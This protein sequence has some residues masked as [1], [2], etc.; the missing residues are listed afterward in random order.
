[1]FAKTAPLK[2]R[3]LDLRYRHGGSLSQ[4]AR[5]IGISKG[6]LWELEDGRQ[7]NPT[8]KLLLQVCKVY[9]ISIRTLLE[10]M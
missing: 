1:M 7:D 3:L 5:E 4:A 9:D 10:G 8:L 2:T 6:H